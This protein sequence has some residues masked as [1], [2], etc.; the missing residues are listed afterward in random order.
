MKQLPIW[1]PLASLMLMLAWV[2]PNATPPWIAFHKDAWAA[3]IFW[4]V[5]IGLLFWRRPAPIRMSLDPLSGILIIAAA[6]TI[7]QWALGILTFSGHALMGVGYFLA[8]GVVVM[9]GRGWEERDPGAPGDFIFWALWLGAM[10]TGGLMLAQWLQLNVNEVWVRS[11]GTTRPFGNLIQPNNAG[12]LLLLGMA[13]LMWFSVRGRLR[14]SIALLGAL[15]LTF[16]L[17]LTSSRIGYL[18]FVCL[19]LCGLWLGSRHADYRVWRPVFVA[20]LCALFLFSYVVTVDWD[21]TFDATTGVQALDRGMTGIRLLVY[22]AY[23]EAALTR[24]WLGFGFEQGVKTQLAAYE[25]G[26]ELPALFTWSH[27]AFLDLATWFGVPMGL[28][29]IATVAACAFIL[30]LSSFS[31]RRSVY[32]AAVFVLF[33]H[34]MVELPLAYAYFLLPACFLAGAMTTGLHWPVLRFPLAI[35][36]V[37]VIGLGVLLATII[38]DYLRIESAF[39]TWRFINA[40]VGRDHPMDVP[41]TVALNQLEALLR[42]LRGSPGEIGDLDIKRFEQVIHLDASAAAIQHLAELQLKR[43]DIA[44]AQRTADMGYVLSYGKTRKQLAARWWYL[45]TLDPAFREVVW[46]SH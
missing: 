32:A 8:A 13:S 44:G 40:R 1:T 33:M 9:V 3:I 29:A 41:N 36:R 5:S 30:L 31:A 35:A 45:G 25:L 22:Q 42:G 26:Y 12:T 6:F 21:T 43:G 46:R 19:T 34:G 23:T 39:N 14:P 2:I 16:A 20:M 24:P 37:L 27:N 28:V 18:S 4:L 10:G 7:L 11:I 38:Y 17:V 15:F